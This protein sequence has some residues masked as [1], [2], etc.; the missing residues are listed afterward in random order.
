MEALATCAIDMPSE[1]K[2]LFF[3]SL[4]SCQISTLPFV[5]LALKVYSFKNVT[6]LTSFKTLSI[7]LQKLT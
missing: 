3:E 7:L 1:F 4:G 5:L 6:A 2:L